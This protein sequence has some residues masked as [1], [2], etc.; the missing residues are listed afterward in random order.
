MSVDDPIEIEEDKALKQK[1]TNFEANIIEF[2]GLRV[3]RAKDEKNV[4][5]VFKG[6]DDPSISSPLCVCS[7]NDNGEWFN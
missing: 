5:I 1:H 3:A 4:Y 2:E 7:F 6:Q